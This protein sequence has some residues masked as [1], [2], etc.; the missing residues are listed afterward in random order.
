MEKSLGFLGAEAEEEGGEEE[1]GEAK[2]VRD[3][4]A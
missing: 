1:E 3:A 4:A 2:L